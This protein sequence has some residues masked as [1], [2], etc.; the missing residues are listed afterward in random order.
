M[1]GQTEFIHRANARVDNAKDDVGAE[2][3][4]D[5]ARAKAA[6]TIR[7]SEIGIAALSDLCLARIR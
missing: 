2:P 4:S 3:L 6:E 1:L 5:Y 7:V